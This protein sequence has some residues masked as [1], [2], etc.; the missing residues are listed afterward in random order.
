MKKDLGVW[1]ISPSSYDDGGYLFQ[2]FRLLM[3]PPIFGV[4]KSLIWQAAAGAGIAL[5]I[6]CI[7]ERTEIGDAYIQ[8]I[9][10][11]RDYARKLILLSAK[12]F[13]LPR[14]IDLARQ[15]KKAGLDVVIGGIGVTLADW[16]VYALLK[17]EGI[18][19][20]VGEGEV[21][22]TQII[23]DA[24]RGA[25]KPLYWQRSFVDLSVAPIPAMPDIIGDGYRFALNRLAGVDTAEGCPFNCSFCSVTVL[26]GRKMERCRARAPEGIIEWVLKTHALGLPIMFL[27]DNFRRSPHYHVLLEKLIRLNAKLKRKL[28]ILVQLDASPDVAEEVPDLAA[29]GVDQVFLGIES[30]DPATLK[31]ANK[32]QNQP[33][34]YKRIVDAFHAHGILVDAGWI[35]GFPWQREEDILNDARLMAA[36][37]DFVAPFRLAALPGTKDYC[38]AVANGE[39]IDWDLNN[40]DTG[41]FVRKLYYMSPEEAKRVSAQVFPIIY[42]LGKALSGPRGLRFDVFRAILYCRLISEWGKRRVG[43]PYQFIMDG[44]PRSKRHLVERPQDSCKGEPLSSEDLGE[45]EAYLESLL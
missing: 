32:K 8:R 44:L 43:R 33:Q 10:A 11:N 27:D 42:S 16:K 29:A 21:T 12:T 24:A 6:F 19:F 13:E 3:I 35:V 9:I 15:F 45:K 36:T 28:E 18:S 14:A 37:F 1:I 20:N 23:Q 2:F 5:D 38:D 25:L 41:H 34:D 26:R 40:Y 30:F 22:A 4:L 39:I 31:Q 17:K 7:N